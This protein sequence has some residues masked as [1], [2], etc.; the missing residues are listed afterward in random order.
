MAKWLS[1]V[2]A[3][4][5]STDSVVA[6]IGLI[7]ACISL[8][9]AGIATRITHNSDQTFDRQEKLLAK[10]TAMVGQEKAYLAREAFDKALDDADGYCSECQQCAPPF[11]V[12]I[13]LDKAKLR[14]AELTNILTAT[15]YNRLAILGSAVWDFDKTREFALK[16]LQKSL[17]PIEKSMSNLV[18]GHLYFV[19]YKTDTNPATLQQGRVYFRSS[20]KLLYDLPPTDAFRFQLGQTEALLAKHELATDTG[21]KRFGEHYEQAKQWWKGL[22]DGDKHIAQLTADI[23]LGQMDHIPNVA[24]LFHA[25][26]SNPSVRPCGDHSCDSRFFVSREVYLRLFNAAIALGKTEAEVEALEQAGTIEV[27]N[28]NG[29][30]EYHHIYFDPTTNHFDTQSPTP[31]LAPAPKAPAPPAPR[32]LSTAREP[33]EIF[34]A[35]RPAEKPA[36][37][38]AMLPT[39]P[40]ASGHPPAQQD[41]PFG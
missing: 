31:T 40:K 32:E 24:C 30:K 17:T 4:R 10:A 36:T 11:A 18:L 28:K 27:S 3:M 5:P 39:P 9:V 6:I 14:E 15:E 41:S 34:P 25:T 22:P 16:A 23:S 21:I 13:P 29:F 19:S 26:P 38:P 7:V 8:V 2:W 33:I 37:A 20:I 12:L 35:E 1:R